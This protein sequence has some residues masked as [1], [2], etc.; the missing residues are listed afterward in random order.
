M[1]NNDHVK[2]MKEIE[3]KLF[4][5]HETFPEVPEHKQEVQNN[6]SHKPFAKEKI[7]K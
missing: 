4:A 1:L 5:L 7:E 6:T 2:I 3:G